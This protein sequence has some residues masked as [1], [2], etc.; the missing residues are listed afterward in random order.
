MR[1]LTLAA[2]LILVSACEG[3]EGAVGPQGEQGI[4]GPEGPE[5]PAGTADIESFSFTLSASGFSQG[6]NIEE[7]A[8]STSALTSEVTGE[9][10]VIAYTDLGTS[11]QGWVAIPLVLPLSSTSVV[12]TQAY[13]QG[14]FSILI[15]KNTS[16]VLASIFDGFRVK[17]IV[18]PPGAGKA[19]IDYSNYEAVAEHYG[20]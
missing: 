10:I 18:I 7:F 6:E 4:A 20:L 3:P 12:L 2:V 1:I 15:L 5:G 14:I 16:E 13:Q 11:G 19:S 9:G 8:H 17:V